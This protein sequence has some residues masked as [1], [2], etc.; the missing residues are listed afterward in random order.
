MAST[1]T[2][3]IRLRIKLRIWKDDHLEAINLMDEVINKIITNSH[4]IDME[5]WKLNLKH[6]KQLKAC[7]ICL[8]NLD[9][10]GCEKFIKKYKE[11]ALKIWEIYDESEISQTC[12]LK[13]D[14]GEAE[15]TWSAHE[16]EGG[17]IAGANVCKNNLENLENYLEEAREFKNKL[18]PQLR[19]TLVN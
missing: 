7:Y 3:N 4:K 14:H 12:V 5:T 11:T 17:Y 8:H 2:Y 18:R 1:S 19:P 15:E 10:V 9:I 16:K 13:A 6:I